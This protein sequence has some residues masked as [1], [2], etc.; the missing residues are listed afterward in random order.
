[1]KNC[2]FI[3]CSLF[4]VTFFCNTSTIVAQEAD[5]LYV[6]LSE[7]DIDESNF[8]T[9]VD[10]LSEL[11]QNTLNNEE[12]CVVFDVL[13]VEDNLTKIFIYESYENLSAFTAHTN[14]A[15]Y[16]KIVNK[17]LKPHIKKETK[18]KVFPINSEVEMD[19]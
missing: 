17:D 9:V 12:G 4:L 3:F 14:S 18:T 11:Q 13:L 5:E 16:K 15:Y 6:V 1:M 7:I 19:E 10:L 2:Y 8:D